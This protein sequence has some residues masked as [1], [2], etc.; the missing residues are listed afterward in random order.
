MG[1]SIDLTDN[2]VCCIE[3]PTF[4]MSLIVA[5]PFNPDL[6][7]NFLLNPGPMEFFFLNLDLKLYP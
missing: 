4:G 1:E 6:D 2:P 7:P 3:Y 5:D